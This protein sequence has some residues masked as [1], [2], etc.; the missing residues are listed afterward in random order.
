MIDSESTETAVFL[1]QALEKGVRPTQERTDRFK[2]VQRGLFAL[3]FHESKIDVDDSGLV[4]FVDEFNKL[5]M[6]AIQESLIDELYRRANVPKGA[7]NG[8]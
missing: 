2:A 4:R 8:T 7:V 3:V 6:V 5:G 1:A